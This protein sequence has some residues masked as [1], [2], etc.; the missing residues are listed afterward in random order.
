MDYQDVVFY[1]AIKKN[2]IMPFAATW[3][4]LDILTL[5]ELSQKEKGKYHMTSFICRIKIWYKLTYLQNRNRRTD[6]ENRLPR[7]KGEGAGGTGSLGLVD[8]NYYI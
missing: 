3:M 4:Q 5:S 2:E 1:S 7:G 6:M 8:I